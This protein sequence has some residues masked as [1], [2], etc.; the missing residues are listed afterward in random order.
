MVP[1]QLDANQSQLRQRGPTL[2]IS[3]ND[4]DDSEDEFGNFGSFNDIRSLFLFIVTL[5][6]AFIIIIQAHCYRYLK[7]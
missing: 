2:A 5:L 4:D 3:N 1:L 7:F 6:F